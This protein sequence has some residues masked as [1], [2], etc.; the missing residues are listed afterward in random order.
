MRDVEEE[1]AI[2]DSP[3]EARSAGD[4]RGLAGAGPR[5]RMWVG[6]EERWRE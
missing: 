6:G 3:A 4:G 5:P 2:M 1:E